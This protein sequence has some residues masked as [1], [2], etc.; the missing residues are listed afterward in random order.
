LS[1][2]GYCIVVNSLSVP[3]PELSV[4]LATV[5]KRHSIEVQW[6]E[7]PRIVPLTGEWCIYVGRE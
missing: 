6:R 3:P 5:L 7:D 1:V 2:R 4:K